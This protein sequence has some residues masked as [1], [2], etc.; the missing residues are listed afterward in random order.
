VGG[1]TSL[2][3]ALVAWHGGTM[4]TEGEIEVLSFVFLFLTRV[5]VYVGAW[6]CNAQTHTHCTWGAQCEPRGRDDTLGGPKESRWTKSWRIFI[7]THVQC[8]HLGIYF[9]RML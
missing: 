8:T 6:V 9:V 1:S 3:R 2:C 7:R 5:G 4:L